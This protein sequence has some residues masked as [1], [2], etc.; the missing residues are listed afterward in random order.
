MR[1]ASLDVAEGEMVTLLGSAGSGKSTLL[2]CVLGLDLPDKGQVLIRGRNLVK[3][4]PGR[5]L[6]FRATTGIM[7]D[8]LGLIGDR[9]VFENVALP[10]RIQDRDRRVVAIKV[11]R[12][13][14]HFGLEARADVPAKRISA[15]E[16][17]LAAVARM[18]IGNPPLLLA[19]DPLRDLPEDASSLVMDALAAA[20]MRGASILLTSRDASLLERFPSS[21]VYEIARGTLFQPLSNWNP[22]PPDADPWD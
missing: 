8:D 14:R 9:T 16:R 22:D 13:L 3:P 2:R 6:S 19:D 1:E 7:L 12:I 21:K 20:R 10:L 4:H 17:R 5:L 11:G 18:I 15:C